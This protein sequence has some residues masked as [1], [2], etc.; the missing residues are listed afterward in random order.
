MYAIVDVETTG[1]NPKTEKIT[2]IA[3][4]LH[5]GRKVTH[6]FTTLIN[7]EK[8]IPYRITQMTGITNK[9]VEDAPRFCD[10]AREI[11]ELTEGRTLVGHHIA[12]DYSFLRNEYSSLGYDFRRE[13]LCTV[14]MSRKLIPHRR[15]YGLGNLCRD[16]D[17]VNPCRHRAAGDAIATAQ[18]FEFLVSIEPA[19]TFISLRGLNSNLQKDK[20]DRLPEQAGVYYFYDEDGNIIY[21][22]K[23]INI[24]E[25]VRSHLSDNLSKKEQEL[26]YRIADIGYE[27]TGNELVALLLE[28]SEIKKYQP[29]Y[30]TSQKRTLLNHGLYTYTDTDGYLRL[31][32]ERD[33]NGT[34]PVLTFNN[35]VAAREFLFQLVEKHE[36][37][38]KLCGLYK[39][40]HACFAF[41]VHKCKGACIHRESPEEYNGRVEKAIRPY[42]FDHESFLIIDAGR[43][44]NEKA[45]V[46][47]E[48][49]RYLGYGY[50]DAGI[51]TSDVDFLRSCVTPFED[52]RDV[53]MIIRGYLSRN[54]VEKI[55]LFK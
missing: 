45:L 5:D 27:L 47:V 43:S 40:Q 22:G 25:R 15:S 12:F 38:Q 30:N 28:S 14:R 9:M 35:Q 6:E 33:A 3:I 23:S 17:I 55:V 10:V 42:L 24:S 13:K 19:I 16:L 11:L 2:E 36:L 4:F 39:T 29:I 49:G 41:H 37:C 20:I 21:I 1:L 48:N 26:K 8:K 31:K 50:M 32:I 52:N 53:R 51:A 18:L 46:M 54:R 34:I 44:V 7:P